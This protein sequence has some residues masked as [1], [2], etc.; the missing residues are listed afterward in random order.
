MNQIERLDA[1]I[2]R[3]QE[4]V[5]REKAASAPPTK[6]Q[7]KAFEGDPLPKGLSLCPHGLRV[8]E[9]GGNFYVCLGCQLGIWV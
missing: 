6:E 3:L 1:K 5:A 8:G 4:R 2:K 7:I 9:S